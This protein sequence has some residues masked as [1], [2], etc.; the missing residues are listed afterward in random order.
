MRAQFVNFKITVL[1]GAIAC[2]TPRRCN[3]SLLICYRPDK[4]C[5]DRHTEVGDDSDAIK[6]SG[7]PA[8]ASPP[9]LINGGIGKREREGGVEVDCEGGMQY[10]QI[11]CGKCFR[12]QVLR[13]FIRHRVPTIHAVS[14]RGRSSR[15]WNATF[16]MPHGMSES[17]VSLCTMRT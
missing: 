16:R 14:T 4:P 15:T 2:I 6:S 3:P 8:Q 1:I 13:W 9:L 7:S 11:D 10:I 17:K 5:S 12:E